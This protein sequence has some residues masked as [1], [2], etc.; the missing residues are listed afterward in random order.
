M[1]K[2]NQK[3]LALTEIK[4]RKRV[5]RIERRMNIMINYEVTRNENTKTVVVCIIKKKYTIKVMKW[6]SIMESILRVVHRPERDIIQ[7]LY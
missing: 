3:V 1:T 6:K 5:L 2:T 4:K 7:Y